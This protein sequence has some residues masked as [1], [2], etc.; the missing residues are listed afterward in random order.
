MTR[1]LYLH[2][3]APKSG[4]TFIQQV[5]AQNSDLL[6]ERGVLVVGPRLQLIRAAMAVREDKR[7]ATLPPEAAQ[8]W[9]QVVA[10]VRDW[11]GESAIV[12]YELF[13]GASQEQATAAL[14]LLEGVEVH[15]VVTARDLGR[16]VASAWQ[17][18]LK[19]GLTKSL[20]EWTPPGEDAP[21]SEW[22]WRTMQPAN[23]AVRWGATVAPSRVHI[24][25]VPRVSSDP[26]ELW[27][28]FAAATDRKSVV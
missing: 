8:S 6:A 12:S 22:G 13:A 20:E 9:E 24:V 26:G 5:L 2:V 10:K 4:T 3:G 1:T 16:A 28:R 18:Q 17:E 25:T 15:V 11:S 7:L 19:F 14:S 27:H 23:V 21:R